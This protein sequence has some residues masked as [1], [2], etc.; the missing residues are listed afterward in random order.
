MLSFSNQTGLRWQLN[1]CCTAQQ[2][3]HASH[4]STLW[5]EPTSE[6]HACAGAGMTAGTLGMQALLLCHDAA[7][8]AAC[9]PQSC[10]RGA[11]LCV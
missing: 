8:G 4:M 5:H 6:Q 1:G 3:D 2:H 11:S 10:S 9:S 7:R